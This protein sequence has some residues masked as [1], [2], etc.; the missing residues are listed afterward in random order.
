[1]ESLVDKF[2]SHFWLAMIFASILWYAFL[3]V[4]VGFKGGVEILAMTRRFSARNED[5]RPPNA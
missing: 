1:M 5:Y 2:F 3:I 4:Y